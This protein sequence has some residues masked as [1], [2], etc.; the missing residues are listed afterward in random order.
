MPPLLG[1][2]KL[3]V[4]RSRTPTHEFRLM[5][6]IILIQVIFRITNRNTLHSR[7]AES[8]RIDV[9]AGTEVVPDNDYLMVQSDGVP[10]HS[11]IIQHFHFN[12]S[13]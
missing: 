12:A 6:Q 8:R 10:S 9:L 11:S 2:P 3:Y 7:G 13:Q 5:N 4:P 1:S